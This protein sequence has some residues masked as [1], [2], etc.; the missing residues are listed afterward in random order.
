MKHAHAAA[1]G[2][3]EKTRKTKTAG[4]EVWHAGPPGA[5]IRFALRHFVLAKISGQARRWRATIALDR[6]H[7]D[8]SSVEVV[9][10]AASLETGATERDNHSRSVGFLDVSTYPE[11]RFRSR[12]IRSTDGDRRFLVVG[13]LTIRDVT[14][15][16]V[17]EVRREGRPDRMASARKGE[18]AFDARATI[19]RADF[20]LRW[21]EELD[22]GGLVAGDRIELE[23]TIEARR[24]PARN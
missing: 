20:G 5:A 15:E 8:R 17:V 3:V 7:P 18:L 4:T 6:H 12:E 1:T 24:G 19:S 9:I 16:V 10:D 11:I 21:H 2:S 22:R 23:M 13:D 14:R